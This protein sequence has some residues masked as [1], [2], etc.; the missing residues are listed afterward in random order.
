MPTETLLILLFAGVHFF[1]STFSGCASMNSIQR[2]QQGIS[3]YFSPMLIAI[4]HCTLSNEHRQRNLFF[5]CSYL[6]DL[7]RI[8]ASDFL[9]TEQDI[10]RAR[11][12]TTGIIEYPFDLDSI[13]FRYQTILNLQALPCW[14]E[15]SSQTPVPQSFIPVS[16]LLSNMWRQSL[17]VPSM[18]STVIV[19]YQHCNYSSP[20]LP[21]LQ[22]QTPS[23]CFSMKSTYDGTFLVPFS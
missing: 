5:S 21:Q 16:L 6:D 17:S 8:I 2:F 22:L 18:N 20:C 12:P 23:N 10:L 9:P 11:V 7:E 19:V 4:H 14:P 13:I 3:I 15:Q 1:F